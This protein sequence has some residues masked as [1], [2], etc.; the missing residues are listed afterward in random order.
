M[1]SPPKT[2]ASLER[3]WGEDLENAIAL[4]VCGITSRYPVSSAPVTLIL[5]KITRIL[6]RG[7]MGDIHIHIYIL[8]A[9]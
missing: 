6:V 4:W 9:R 5:V 2:Y 1:L 8:D 7:E 3:P